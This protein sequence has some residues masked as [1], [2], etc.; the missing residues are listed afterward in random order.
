MGFD[1][2]LSFSAAMGA[3]IG[4]LGELQIEPYYVYLHDLI[5]GTDELRT[6]LGAAQH[7]EKEA[8]VA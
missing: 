1:P 8:R 6:T 4:S 3:L 7:I 2:D 5:P